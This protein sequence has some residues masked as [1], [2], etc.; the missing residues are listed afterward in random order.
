MFEKNNTPYAIINLIGRAFISDQNQ[1]PFVMI[2]SILESIPTEVK[3]KILDFH[4]EATSEKQAMGFWCAG[5]LSL[6]YGTHI[7]VQTADERIIN[8]TGF[9]TDIGMCGAYDSIIGMRKDLVLSRFLTGQRVRLSPG[10]N[11]PWFC[12]LLCDINKD[13][14]ICEKIERICWRY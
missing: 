13:T 12:G 3:I 11:E 1:D 2:N 5:K 9:I 8:G 6:V 4:A 10:E 14:G 7:H